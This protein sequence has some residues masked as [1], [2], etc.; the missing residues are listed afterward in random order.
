[1]FPLPEMS[2]RGCSVDFQA[3]GLL[4]F[5]FSVDVLLCLFGN[6]LP[7]VKAQQSKQGSQGSKRGS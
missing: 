7:S 3:K 2:E 1:M 6:V 5:S 4:L